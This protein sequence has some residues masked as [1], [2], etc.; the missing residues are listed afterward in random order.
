M[1]CPAFLIKFTVY[2]FLDALA[3]RRAFYARKKF[4]DFIIIIS[5]AQRCEIKINWQRKLLYN[6]ML[7]DDF[8]LQSAYEHLL[9]GKKGAVLRILCSEN[10]EKREIREN[11]FSH[12]WHGYHGF[13]SIKTSKTLLLWSRLRLW[14]CS[15]LLFLVSELPNKS[16]HPPHQFQWNL[17]QVKR[18]TCNGSCTL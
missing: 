6:F 10:I 15:C 11:M 16:P 12:W 8:A 2:S 14:C 5:R 7:F 18:I 1:Y 9:E 3:L 13:I 17:N 4:K